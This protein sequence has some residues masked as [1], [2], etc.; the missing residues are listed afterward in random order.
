MSRLLS[1]SCVGE[2]VDE[3]LRSSLAP[4]GSDGRV[5]GT[6]S[7]GFY[8]RTHS[9]IFAVG[10][11]GIPPGPLHLVLEVAPPPPTEGSRVRLAADRLYAASCEI[12]LANAARHRPARL[13]PTQLLAIAPVLAALDRMDS[14]PSDLAHVWADVRVAVGQADLHLARRLLQGVG[15]GLTPTGDDAL[16]AMILF[17]SWVCPNSTLPA[18]VAAQCATTDLSRSFLRWAAVGQ[19]I[20]PVHS[21]LDAAV[22]LASSPSSRVCSPVKQDRFLAAAGVVASIGGSSGKAMLAGLGLAATFWPFGQ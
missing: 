18:E 21:L 12:T 20:Q 19:S 2:G 15:G 4:A 7:S 6:F 10:G 5:V 1:A 3:V 16:A 13:T 17:A 22:Q 14:V 9:A 11:P 8:V